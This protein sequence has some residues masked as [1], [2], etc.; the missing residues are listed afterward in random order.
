MS[1]FWKP[2]MKSLVAIAA[3]GTSIAFGANAQTFDDVE[4]AVT[5][6]EQFNEALIQSDRGTAPD[7][8]GSEIDGEAGVFVLKKN[9]IFSVSAIVGAG[10]IDNPGRTL[11]LN[12]EGSAS[13]NFA[14]SAAVNTRIA[15]QV[16]AG[17]NIVLSGEE[18]ERSGAPDSRNAVANVYAG[19]PFF[20][21]NVY[22]SVSA[23]YGL[24]MDGTFGSQTAF[25]GVSANAQTVRRIRDNMILRPAVSVA[26]QWS[27]VSAQHNTSATVSADV[28]WA[29]PN[30]FQATGGVSY[31][32]RVYD[33]FFE[34]ITFVERKDDV[35]RVS[36][37]V[38]RPLTRGVVGI[39]S[40]SYV[41]QDSK[42][43]L[44]EY[45]ALNGGISLKLVKKF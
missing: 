8:A 9:K 38:S 2:K 28:I 11:D 29:L 40:V 18:Y 1:N 31:T 30:S 41:T 24:S 39:A 20:D 7:E 32:Y 27:E 22:G 42:F 34:D 10:Y 17:A 21:G 35:I 23:T 26:R 16:D 5:Q 45:D 13:A 19:Q 6:G 25:Y 33:D 4:S 44:S 3:F 37:S 14:L 12:A 36:A 15:Q 43:F